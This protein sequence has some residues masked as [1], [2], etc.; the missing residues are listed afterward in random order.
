MALSSAW[1]ILQ[2]DVSTHCTLR[3]PT[4]PHTAF[5]DHWRSEHVSWAVVEKLLPHARRFS[6]VHLQGWGEPLLHPDLPAIVRAFTQAGAPCGLTTNGVHLSPEL[7]RG[8]LDAGLN[9]LTVSL[10]GATPATQAMLR[11]PSRLEDIL[12]G[13][14]RFK[15]M[16]GSSCQVRLSF[17]RQPENQHELSEAVRLAKRT[18]LDGVLCVNPTFQ[19]VPEHAGRLVQPGKAARK[20]S[21]RARW[22]AFFNR[23]ELSIVHVVPERLPSCLNRPQENMTVAVDGGVSPCV[24]LQLPLKS[25]PEGFNGPLVS[26]GNVLEKDLDEIWNEPGYRAFREPFSLREAACDQLIGE[27]MEC[28]EQEG[29]LKD[30]QA[31][32]ERMELELPLPAECSGC[33]KASGL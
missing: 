13:I 4:C 28:M 31:S 6:L 19:A 30:F 3:C 15:E 7:G 18:G 26:F 11:P 10:S 23:Q 14:G 16:A 17:L 25:R 2:L 32:M 9:A 5:A 33:L 1:N 12:A 20:A 21:R 24:F 8:L 27:Y 29:A 22:A